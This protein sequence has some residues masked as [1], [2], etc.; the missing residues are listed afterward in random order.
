MHDPT[1]LPVPTGAVF[2]GVD[3]ASADHAVCVVDAA[4]AVLWR[5]TVAHS[6]AGLTRLTSRLRE[7]GVVRV[8]IERPDGPVVEALLDA[9]LRVA[10]VPPRQVKNLR[11]RYRGAGQGR[12]VRR[13]SAGR[14][15]AH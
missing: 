10:V 8:G 14:H 9:E 12:P 2:A 5:H 11:S 13:L 15:D 3:W 4:G 6:R 1:V 7:Y